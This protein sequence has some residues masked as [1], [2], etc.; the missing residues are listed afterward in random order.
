MLNDYRQPVMIEEF[1][2]GDEVTVGVIGNAPPQ[3]LGIM[4]ILPRRKDKDFVYSL[5]VKRDYL[6][7]VDYECLV[8]LSDSVL[9]RITESSLKVF[10]VL[11]CR[12]FARLDYRISPE[13]IPY[14][15]EINALPG[16]GSYSDLIIMAL[17]LGW[18]HYQVIQAVLDAALRRSPQCVSV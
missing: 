17:K 11:G 6:N 15:I 9:S 10:D 3:V 14:F 5:E 1:I 8:R 12:D 2:S 4:R 7:L 18:N 13:G 16:L